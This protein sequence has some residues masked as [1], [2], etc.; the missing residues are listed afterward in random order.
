M[1]EILLKKAIERCEIVSLLRGDT[2]YEVEV[3]KYTSDVF[4]TDVNAVLVNCFY[5]QIGCI[6]NIREL[7]LESFDELLK[8]SK[9]DRYTAILYFD[10]CIFQE[11][12]GKA[13]FKIDRNSIAKKIKESI[14]NIK[15]EL[16]E[17]IIFPNGMEKNNALR[18]IEA[19]NQY[20]IKKY[21]ISI[22]D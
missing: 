10:A 17:E 18:N 19:F 1:Y 20:Y 3:S 15:K 5:K 22:L 16:K 13:T 9:S 2:E 21:G 4:P 12:K 14:K 7:F 11:E 8:G 6:D